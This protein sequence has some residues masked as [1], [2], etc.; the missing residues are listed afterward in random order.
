MVLHTRLMLC[1]ERFGRRVLL[2]CW[3]WSILLPPLSQRPPFSFLLNKTL[4]IHPRR[5]VQILGEIE[6]YF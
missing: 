2:S 4:Y 5:V 1:L 6:R 3:N